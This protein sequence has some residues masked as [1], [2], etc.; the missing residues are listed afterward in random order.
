VDEK[1]RGWEEEVAKCLQNLV[2]WFLRQTGF[3][4]FNLFSSFVV[5]TR[6]GALRIGFYSPLR[7][8]DEYTNLTYKN[9]YQ[10]IIAMM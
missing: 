10:N 4:D 5:F 1:E 3:V 9:Y 7:S 2:K 6:C 8:V